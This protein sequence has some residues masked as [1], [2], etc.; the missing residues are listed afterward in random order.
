MQREQHNAINV[1]YKPNRAMLA[2]LRWQSA[3][4]PSDSINRKAV[5]QHRFDRYPWMA[6]YHWSVLGRTDF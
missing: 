6:A 3:T 5:D 2:S 1:I 4:G